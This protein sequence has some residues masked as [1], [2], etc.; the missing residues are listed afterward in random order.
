MDIYGLY[1]GEGLEEAFRKWKHMSKEN[2]TEQ[3]LAFICDS[4]ANY[5]FDPYEPP[6]WL[7]AV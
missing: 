5:F 6:K 7:P 1:E 4:L 3:K 2:R